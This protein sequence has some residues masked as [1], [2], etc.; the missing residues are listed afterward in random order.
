MKGEKG[1]ELHL[2]NIYTFS[3]ISHCQ[4]IETM[5]PLSKRATGRMEDRQAVGGKDKQRFEPVAVSL[6]I[7]HPFSAFYLLLFTQRMNTETPL[8][9]FSL[10]LKVSHSD[11]GKAQSGMFA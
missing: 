11:S 10:H 6:Y 5:M 2:F 3:G 7:E 4:G 9:H 1:Q 8:T